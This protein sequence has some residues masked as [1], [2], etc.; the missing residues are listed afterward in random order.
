MKTG[1]RQLI[2]GCVIAV[3]MTGCATQNPGTAASS[4]LASSPGAPTAWEY[5]VVSGQFNAALEKEINKAAADGWA[6]V[7]ASSQDSNW[8]FAV[9]KRL[10]SSP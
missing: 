7:A 5:K 3:S 10:K 2:A 6:L 9:M 8:G 1:I 4:Q